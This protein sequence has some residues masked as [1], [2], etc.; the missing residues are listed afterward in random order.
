MDLFFILFYYIFFYAAINSRCLERTNGNCHFHV[1]H[2]KI[3]YLLYT[4]LIINLVTNL[5]YD[6]IV[7]CYVEPAILSIDYMVK[8]MYVAVNSFVA[9][10]IVVSVLHTF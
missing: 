5:R 8:S 2:F 1:S 4:I 10:Y 6:V 7:F 3:A 9:S